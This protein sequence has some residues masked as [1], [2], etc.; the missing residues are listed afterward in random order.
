MF[1]QLL[2]RKFRSTTLRN[3]DRFLKLGCERLEDRSLL[4]VLFGATGDRI[5]AMKEW[6]G[7]GDDPTY[8]EGLRLAEQLCDWFW[9]CRYG[10]GEFDFGDEADFKRGVDLMVQI[11]RKRF[12]R[13]RSCQPVIAR[14]TFG[15]RSILYRLKAKID[16]TRAK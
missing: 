3:R 11:G 2:P 10:G 12:T 14:Q 13:G 4:A 1:S 6:H 16:V 9:E 15:I 8:N 7:V 5:E